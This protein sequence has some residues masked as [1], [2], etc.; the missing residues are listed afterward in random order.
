MRTSAI[1]SFR[2]AS[3]GDWGVLSKRAVRGQAPEVCPPDK[4]RSNGR[5]GGSGTFA[6]IAA[7]RGA[8]TSG[9]TGDGS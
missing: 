7:I 6:G 1:G 8:L 9:D 5:L 2:R 4:P 3:R